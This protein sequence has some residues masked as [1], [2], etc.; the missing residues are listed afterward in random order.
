MMRLQGKRILVTGGA[1]GIG[2][3]VAV[4]FAREGARVAVVDIAHGA[5]MAET[6]EFLAPVA[7]GAH[8][9][10]AAD[11]ADEAS[12]ERM[13]AAVLAEFG[14]LDVLINNAGI[15]IGA[16]SDLMTIEQFD[17]VLAVNLRGTF[18]CSR[19]A[20][21]H[22]LASGT[23]G[24]I[25][26]TSS[27]HEVIPKPGYLGYAASKGAIGNVTRT[28]AL[29]YAGRGIRV[30][31]VAPGAIT[32]PMNGGWKDDPVKRAEIERHIPMA[33]AGSPE[34]VAALFAFLASDDASYVTGQTFFVD[35]GLSLYGDFAHNW[36]S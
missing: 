4:R 17:R 31:A 2:R 20:I 28:L 26:N 15:Q 10:F 30:N 1:Q 27:V 18:L 14:G 19:A 13:M 11:V 22:F 9:G 24:S 35:G 3:A 8:A 25:I 29:E 32:T 33:R 36:S 21:G 12:V 5:A 23:Q 7:A 16:A 6:L 34:E